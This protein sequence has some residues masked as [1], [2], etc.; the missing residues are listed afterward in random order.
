MVARAS[1]EDLAVAARVRTCRIEAGLT[2]QQFAQCLGISYQQVFRYET[3]ENRI[4]GGVLLRMART[5]GRPVGDLFPYLEA[6]V[7]PSEHPHPRAV[8]ELID[9]LRAGMSEDHVRALLLVARA[10][11][12]AGR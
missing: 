2:Q 4:S 11:A 3:G 1:T 10:L 7:E 5:L 12:V 8:K 6:P 9:L